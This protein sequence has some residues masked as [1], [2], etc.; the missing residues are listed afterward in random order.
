MHDLGKPFVGHV[1]DKELCA[2]NG[3]DLNFM[4]GDCPPSPLQQS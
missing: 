3:D 1:P 2:G 4:C